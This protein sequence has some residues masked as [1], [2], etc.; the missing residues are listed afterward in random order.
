M[1]CQLPISKFSN[2]DDKVVLPRI[3]SYLTE[4]TQFL[5]N[6]GETRK[7]NDVTDLQFISYLFKQPQQLW[8]CVERF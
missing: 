8:G 6:L 3:K 1:F 5:I 4:L 7:L 2:I